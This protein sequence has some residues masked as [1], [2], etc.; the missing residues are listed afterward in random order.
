MSRSRVP[1]GVAGALLLSACGGEPQSSSTGERVT[2]GPGA[3]H[4]G[5]DAWVR[6]GGPNS[7]SAAY[8]TIYNPTTDTLVVGQVT[9]PDASLVEVHETTIHDDMAHM[10]PVPRLVVAPRDSLVMRPGGVH[11]MIA[12]RSATLAPGDTL[13]LSVELSGRRVEVLAEVRQ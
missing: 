9:L 1:R 12:T 10:A 2:T 4:V 8:L 7:P 5:S 11:L 3:P 13:R 6:A